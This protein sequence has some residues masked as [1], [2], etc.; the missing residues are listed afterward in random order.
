MANS[1]LVVVVVD[2][3]VELIPNCSVAPVT[4]IVPVFVEN[5]E[6]VVVVDD[7]VNDDEDNAVVDD[8]TE[9][10]LDI[11]VVVDVLIVVV[12]RELN[13]AVVVVAMA[14]V[15]LLIKY[16][17]GQLQTGVYGTV[18]IPVQNE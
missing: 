10:E 8:I 2:D 11:F 17:T 13:T 7:D 4:E 14:H 6:T 15:L 9:L 1:K 5:V 16:P 3:D 12:L 18:I